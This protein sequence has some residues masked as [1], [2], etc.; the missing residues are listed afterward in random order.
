[1]LSCT[2]KNMSK[3]YYK[4][5]SVDKNASDTEIKKA[6]YKVAAEHHPDKGGDAE[7]FKTANEAYQ[8]LSDKDKRKK[9]DTYGSADGQQGF[10]GGGAQG[11]DFSGFQS[12]F[13]GIN[14]EDIFSAF[15]G[16]GF[17]NSFRR[18]RDIESETT[19]T[20]LESMEG[21]KREIEV[22]KYSNGKKNGNQK[23]SFTVP[24]GV[25]S[26]Q[27]LRVA[28]YGETI[29]NGRSGDLHVVIHVKADKHFTRLNDRDLLSKLYIKLSESLLGAKKK[30]PTIHGEKEISIP[31]GVMH[32][33]ILR[34]K[35]EGVQGSHKGDLM[36]EISV[37][38]PRKISKKARV[39]LEELVNEGF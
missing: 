26:G 10:G 15:G 32:G 2:S 27:T 33:Q 9:Y 31:E 16:G 36:I 8:V 3:D 14:M 17:G 28:G 19:L 34:M 6:F 29:D 22:P 13:G 20:F 30:I 39:L 11:F 37:E 12:G 5:L 24:A 38:L 1:M 23:V 4:T 35:G 25:Q 21:V 18:G 7:K